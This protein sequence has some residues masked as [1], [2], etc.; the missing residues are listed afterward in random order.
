MGNF[1]ETES[2]W[3]GSLS[4][5]NWT[6]HHKFLHLSIMSFVRFIELVMKVWLASW[7]KEQP[8]EL[9]AR[10][11]ISHSANPIYRRQPFLLSSFRTL[12]LVARTR[13]NHSG[14]AARVIS[15][16]KVIF[17]LD[18]LAT[19][20][21]GTEV[22]QDEGGWR[23][24][25]CMS[26]R[27]LHK[28]S[29]NQPHTRTGHTHIPEKEKGK[30]LLRRRRCCHLTKAKATQRTNLVLCK[31]L[32]NKLEADRGLGARLKTRLRCVRIFFW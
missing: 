24:F 6:E 21:G 28:H 17:S 10:T 13:I 9:I 7:M 1:K 25:P 5:R 30:W 20:W 27:R 14:L 15:C 4:R 11:G 29:D 23:V 3:N 8:S 18:V 19:L 2:I 22:V 31:Y 26:S 16:S 12:S 32:A